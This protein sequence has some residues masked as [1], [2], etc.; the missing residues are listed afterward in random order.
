MRTVYP[1]DPDDPR[2]TPY[3]LATKLAEIDAAPDLLNL[4]AKM[5]V[6]VATR[7][8]VM[9]DV[10]Y[11][12]GV[13]LLAGPASKLPS[14]FVPSGTIT[15]RRMCAEIL[16]MKSEPVITLGGDNHEVN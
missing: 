15:A 1:R 11:K 5:R 9:D 14:S 3:A 8:V 12:A 16:I 10:L 6:M 2:V 7:D 4:I 13:M